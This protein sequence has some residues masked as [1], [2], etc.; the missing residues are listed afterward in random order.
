MK[1]SFVQKIQLW[2]TNLRKMEIHA[3]MMMAKLCLLFS[4]ILIAAMEINY[5]LV[6]GFGRDVGVEDE[7]NN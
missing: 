1:K 2:G 5:A 4:K 3:A 7:K 6:M